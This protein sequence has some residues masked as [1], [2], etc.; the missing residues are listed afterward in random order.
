MV[1]KGVLL[2]WNT[3]SQFNFTL[4][5]ISVWFYWKANYLYFLNTFFLIVLLI[6]KAEPLRPN[7]FWDLTWLQGRVKG[8]QPLWKRGLKQIFVKIFCG[9][10][11]RGKFPIVFSPCCKENKCWQTNGNEYLKAEILATIIYII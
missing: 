8:C 6:W 11:T 5:S 1:R 9:Y 10:P 7:L 2:V 3:N 4:R